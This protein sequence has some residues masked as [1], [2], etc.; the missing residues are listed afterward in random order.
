MSSM[1]GKVI[2]VTRMHI[3]RGTDGDPTECPCALAIRERFPDVDVEVCSQ[4]IVVDGE[5]FSSSDGLSDW[6]DEYDGVDIHL[7]SPI[8][9]MDPIALRFTTDPHKVTHTVLT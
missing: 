1:A 5:V 2:R 7:G 9:A 3:E 8:E 6:I 4:E